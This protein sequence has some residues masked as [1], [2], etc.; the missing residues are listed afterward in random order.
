[1]QRLLGPGIEP[2]RV[3]PL[4]VAAGVWSLS[5]VGRTSS[6]RWRARIGP[7]SAVKVGTLGRGQRAVESSSRDG[8]SI[9]LRRPSRANPG[10][11]VSGVQAAHPARAPKCVRLRGVVDRG[12]MSLELGVLTPEN[13]QSVEQARAIWMEEAGGMPDQSGQFGCV[14]EGGLRCV[15]GRR[16]AVCRWPRCRGRLLRPYDDCVGRLGSR[17]PEADRTRAPA[18]VGFTSLRIRP[19]EPYTVEG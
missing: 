1:V 10:V 13:A 2:E 17:S 5:R 18:R 12:A 11:E 16:V 19:G 3:A 14:R 6:R 8:A 4:L 9:V 15:H 7:A